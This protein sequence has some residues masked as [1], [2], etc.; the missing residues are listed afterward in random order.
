[1]I[2]IRKIIIA[3]IGIICLCLFIGCRTQRATQTTFISDKQN[4]RKWD[5]LFQFR[6]L[7][8]FEKVRLSHAEI[9]QSDKIDKTYIKDSTASRFDADGKKIGE[10]KYHYERHDVSKK[11]FQQIRDSLAYYMAY[12]DSSSYYHA[13]CD[14]LNSSYSNVS[15]D[16]VYV[17]KSLTF[18]QK[19]YLC[20]GKFFLFILVFIVMYVIYK[21]KKGGKS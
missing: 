5:S 4:E 10:D 17:E 7:Q 1:M 14:S 6:I 20:M 16:K 3:F 21:Y 18:F 12:K 19:I 15:K 11:E 2:Y 9:K 13:K 8:E